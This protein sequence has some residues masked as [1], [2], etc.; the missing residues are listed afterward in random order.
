MI[1]NAT[2]VNLQMNSEVDYLFSPAEWAAIHVH[3]YY[4]SQ[5]RGYEVLLK[6]VIR[7]WLRDYAEEWM[8]RQQEIARMN[9][10]KLTAEREYSPAEWKSIRVHRYFLSQRYS[11]WVGIRETIRDWENNYGCIWRDKRME[12]SSRNQMEQILKYKWLESEKAG[13]DIGKPAI[14]DWI[15]KYAALWRKWW[16]SE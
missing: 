8:S 14:A 9:G 2:A 11:R 15:E 16:E 3:K 7:D 10:N 5:Q 4:L 6:E 12:L 13:H 1:Y